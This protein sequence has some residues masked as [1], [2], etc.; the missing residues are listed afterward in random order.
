METLSERVQR[1]MVKRGQP[2]QADLARACKVTTASVSDW[3]TGKT[4]SLSARTAR[5]AAAYFGCDRDWIGQGIGQ[6][7]WIESHGLREAGA[8]YREEQ[9]SVHAA[10]DTIGLA[11]ANVPEKLR[12]ELGDAMRQ[13]A[14]YGGRPTYR[15]TV[16]SLLID[17]PTGTHSKRAATG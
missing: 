2:S 11:L 15:L 12:D 3:I 13:W 1:A 7:N 17:Q 9:P 10:L 14:R 5:L 8:A 4:K 16:E 6:P